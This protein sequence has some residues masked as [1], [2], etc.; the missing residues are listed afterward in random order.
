MP[1]VVLKHRLLAAL[2]IC[3]S[4]WALMPFVSLSKELFDWEG[5]V[6]VYDV[7]FEDDFED[8]RAS[9]WSGSFPGE[10]EIVE[11]DE[12]AGFFQRATAIDDAALPEAPFAAVEVLVGFSPAGGKTFSLR[13]RSLDETVE[14]QGSVRRDDGVWVESAWVRLAD[15]ARPLEIDWRRALAETGDGALFVSAGGDLL[16]WLTDLDNDRGYVAS[17]GVLSRNGRPLLTG[18]VP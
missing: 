13:L 15:P 10:F 2:A 7:I 8:G 11:L 1:R 5:L 6:G 3:L 14:I 16:L 17:Y 4:G 9:R 12:P 18:L